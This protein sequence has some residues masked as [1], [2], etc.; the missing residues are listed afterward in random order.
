MLQ[1]VHVRTP[2][3]VEALCQTLQL[4]QRKLNPSVMTRE[5]QSGDRLESEWRK[6]MGKAQEEAS[7]TACV[8]AGY[9][10]TCLILLEE[11]VLPS[12]KVRA[13]A[14]LTTSVLAVTPAPMYPRELC[15]ARLWYLQSDAWAGKRLEWAAHLREHAGSRDVLLDTKPPPVHTPESGCK[16]PTPPPARGQHTEGYT[17]FKCLNK[18]TRYADVLSQVG[19]GRPPG[20]ITLHVGDAHLFACRAARCSAPT[21]VAGGAQV[22]A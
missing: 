3:D 9:P 6:H 16:V 5:W 1:P 4:L 17:L 10:A 13:W 7:G 11:H 18:A 2:P 19:M 21:H 12:H 20:A 8:D 15:L 22:C 14:L